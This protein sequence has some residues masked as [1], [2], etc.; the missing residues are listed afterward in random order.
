[1]EKKIMEKALS[2]IH[3][4][5]ALFLL[6]NIFIL[7]AFLG[8]I[9]SYALEWIF[10]IDFPIFWLFGIILVINGVIIYVTRFFGISLRFPQFINFG[11]LY[12][13]RGEA[14]RCLETFRWVVSSVSFSRHSKYAI[15]SGPISRTAILWFGAN[16]EN[17]NSAAAEEWIDRLTECV[18][19]PHFIGV[20][21]ILQGSD[22]GVDVY[23]SIHCSNSWGG[24]AYR[25][26][27]YSLGNST[28]DLAPSDTTPLLA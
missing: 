25:I 9:L 7:C 12:A 10:D 1:M 13:A 22:M 17:A 6:A 16:V 24:I 8:T 18:A 20:A 15:S 19:E 3:L 21:Y 27:R 5:H 26:A 23:A 4:F 28:Q 14:S 2:V 11:S